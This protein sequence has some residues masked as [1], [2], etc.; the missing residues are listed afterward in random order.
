MIYEA[1]F[2]ASF[3]DEI[4][5]AGISFLITD[6]SGNEIHKGNKSIKANTINEAEFKALNILCTR[7]EELLKNKKILGKDIIKIFGDN[8]VVIN[9]IL[10]ETEFLEVNNGLRL[11]IIKLFKKNKNWHLNWISTKQNKSDKE[12]K[13][14][15]K[16]IKTSKLNPKKIIVD[17]EKDKKIEYIEYQYEILKKRKNKVGKI[18]IEEIGWI[19]II[20]D[21]KISKDITEMK[22]GSFYINIK[23]AYIDNEVYGYRI[24]YEYITIFADKIIAII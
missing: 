16:R 8:K 21:S 24:S 3:E 6:E 10:N 11:K 17:K 13:E 18:L 23:N 2:D 9:T 7:L 12:S 15:L 22:F 20:L 4:K 5:K 1:W 19:H 14:A